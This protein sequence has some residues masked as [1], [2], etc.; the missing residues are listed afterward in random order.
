[1]SSVV[2][3][4]N[5]EVRAVLVYRACTCTWGFAL[6]PSSIFSHL[7][8]LYKAVACLPAACIPHHSLDQGSWLLIQKIFLIPSTQQAAALSFAVAARMA[9]LCIHVCRPLMPFAAC[10][11]TFSWHQILSP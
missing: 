3:A 9:Y 8:M 1:M 10:T 7:R 5:V 2:Q 11:C 4:A 6:A